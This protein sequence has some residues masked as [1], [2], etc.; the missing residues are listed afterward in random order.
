MNR[1]IFLFFFQFFT[2]NTFPIIFLRI[3]VAS[4]LFDLCEDFIIP[5]KAVCSGL[6]QALHR[7][8][9]THAETL[10][11]LSFMKLILKKSDAFDAIFTSEFRE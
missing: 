7:S 3:A 2:S 9:P 4:L 11:I 6:T 1:S 5:A 8:I 10:R